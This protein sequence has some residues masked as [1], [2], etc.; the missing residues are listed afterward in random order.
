MYDMNKNVAIVIIGFLVGVNL[1]IYWSEPTFGVIFTGILLCGAL[2]GRFRWLS[3]V[4]IG[5][6]IGFS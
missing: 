3:A 1:W 2:L 5:L 6:V 4:V